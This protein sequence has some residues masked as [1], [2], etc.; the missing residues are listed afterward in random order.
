MWDACGHSR[1]DKEPPRR[2]RWG[3]LWTRLVPAGAQGGTGRRRRPHL[4][5]P[6][7]TW[8]QRE[9]CKGRERATARNGKRPPSREG[10]LI[11]DEHLE[12]QCQAPASA[13][14][15]D[16]LASLSGGH[17]HHPDLL[18]QTQEVRTLVQGHLLTSAQT[19][20]P[21]PSQDPRQATPKVVFF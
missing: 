10:R 12:P 6:G 15:P 13:S 11:N 4:P 18:A 1:R 9:H 19:Q 21:R 8:R 2:P 14:A 5:E 7:G 17:D 20:R 16:R 3:S